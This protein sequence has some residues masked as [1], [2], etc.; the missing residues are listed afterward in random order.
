MNHFGSRVEVE[1]RRKQIYEILL[2]GS[3]LSQQGMIRYSSLRQ[4]VLVSSS[5]LLCRASVQPKQTQK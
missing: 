3:I 5:Y 4:R 1:G 2:L